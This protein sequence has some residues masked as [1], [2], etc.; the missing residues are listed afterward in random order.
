MIGQSLVD[1]ISRQVAGTWDVEIHKSR[2][3]LH[4]NTLY[5]AQWQNGNGVD[6]DRLVTLRWNT[7][8]VCE[9]CFS[10]LRRQPART[11]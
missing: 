6:V 8:E 10:R 1:K 7:A 5:A 11:K 4:L 9:H 3:Q 2:D